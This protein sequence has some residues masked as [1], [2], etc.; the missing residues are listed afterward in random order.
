MAAAQ[1][2]HAF[3]GLAGIALLGVF[4]GAA[5]AVADVNALILCVSLIGC[6]FILY[7]FRIGVVL[8]I[9]MMPLSASP[10]M[11][12]AMLGITG[13]N[14]LNLLLL[15]T[16]GSCLLNGLSDGSLR[17]SCP[18]RSFGCTSYPFWSPASWARGMSAKLHRRSSLLP[19]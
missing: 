8:L 10:L 11:P 2:R 9:V 14:P 19:T 1:A 16:L 18:A 12:H 17:T 13:L 4:W 5:V 3:T 15:G 7:D 6:A